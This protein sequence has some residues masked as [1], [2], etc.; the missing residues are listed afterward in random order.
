[1]SSYYKETYR[2]RLN[3]YGLDYQS[4]IQNQR[5]R[6][7]DNY[8]Y[9]TIYRVDFE[10]DGNW[11]P[12]SLERYKQDFSET[13][14]YLLT[15]NDVIIPN[16]T[17]LMIQ[18][19]DNTVTPWMIWWLEHI[20]SSGYNKY[21][22]LKMTHYLKWEVAGK[23]IE[24]WAYFSGTGAAAISDAVRT[25]TGKPI[26]SENNNLHTFI[27]TQNETICRDLYFEVTQGNITQAYVVTEFDIHSTPGV[28]YVTVDHVPV[29]PKEQ[30]VNESSNDSKEDFFWLQGGIQQ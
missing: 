29:R 2:R 13:S 23:I 17:V 10:F 11:V 1:M 6:D 24:Q 19:K 27:T 20:E 18:S 3:R 8:L 21:V 25:A 22:V 5:E 26:Y 28:N 7:F 15:K 14:G 12:G 16:G 4:R 9:K 30:I